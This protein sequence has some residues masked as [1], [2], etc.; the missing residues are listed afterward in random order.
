MK[1]IFAILLMSFL[2]SPCFGLMLVVS[3]YKVATKCELVQPILTFSVEQGQTT[4][5]VEKFSFDKSEA[6]GA[7]VGGNLLQEGSISV[8]VKFH[9][10]YNFA[11]KETYVGEA[12]SVGVKAT[13]TFGNLNITNELAYMVGNTQP[14]LTWINNSLQ[15]IV[16]MTGIGYGN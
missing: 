2:V 6:V 11:G 3:E 13:Y 14:C 4:Y 8:P 1:H 7:F 5:G 16:F 9:A 15:Q 10:L 12:I